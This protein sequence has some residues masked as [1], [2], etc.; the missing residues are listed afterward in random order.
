MPWPAGYWTNACPTTASWCVARAHITG[1]QGS[2]DETFGDDDWTCTITWI[3][4]LSYQESYITLT[5]ISGCTASPSSC[6]CNVEV[7]TVPFEYSNGVVHLA[8]QAWT[9]APSPSP[10]QSTSDHLA[11]II[12][13]SVGGLMAVLLLLG[14]MI[15]RKKK[16]TACPAM[17]VPPLH[18]PIMHDVTHDP[19]MVV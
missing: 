14:I 11:L 12:G 6:R 9:L 15:W 8:D 5:P 7:T 2:F 16:Q 10:P 19:V 18:V 3:M 1:A 17:R 13:V 4:E